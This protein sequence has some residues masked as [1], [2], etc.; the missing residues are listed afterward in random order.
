MFINLLGRNVF[1]IIWIKVAP[2]PT[3]Q[4][5]RIAPTEVNSSLRYLFLCRRVSDSK[6]TVIKQATNFIFVNAKVQLQ[7]IISYP[8]I[9]FSTTEWEHNSS[10]QAQIFESRRDGS[11]ECSAWQQS[12][13][14]SRGRS[15][16]EE[17]PRTIS[18]KQ[19]NRNFITVFGLPCELA[20][21]GKGQSNN[22]SIQQ[23]PTLDLQL[24]PVAKTC[25]I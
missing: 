13:N 19:K 25:I 15:Q 5:L 23:S 6:I 4:R 16:G 2:S 3:I 21:Q 1:N 20:Q 11:I 12:N 22:S 10:T 14:P 9:W 24:Y 17:P 8:Y 7:I 18:Q